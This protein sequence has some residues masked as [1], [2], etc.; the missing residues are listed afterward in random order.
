MALAL[1]AGCQQAHDANTVAT[2]NGKAILRSEVETIYQNNLGES[3]QQPSKVQAHHAT[4]YR[5]PAD[6]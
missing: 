2:V 4:E 1:C 5:A 3:H 6:R